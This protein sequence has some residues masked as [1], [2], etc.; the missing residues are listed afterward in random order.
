MPCYTYNFKSPV[1]IKHARSYQSGKNQHLDL[2]FTCLFP[3]NLVTLLF[4]YMVWTYAG[5]SQRGFKLETSSKFADNCPCS[6]PWKRVTFAVRNSIF[7]A[8]TLHA[9]SYQ[10]GKNQHLGLL[11]LVTLTSQIQVEYRWNTRPAGQFVLIVGVPCYT[12]TFKC[13]VSIRL[14]LHVFISI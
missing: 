2:T 8:L 12:Y 10:S 13:P 14:K 7:I 4:N 6:E 1:S 5:R 3:Y 9:R 11:T